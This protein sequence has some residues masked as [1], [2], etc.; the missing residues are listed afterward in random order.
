MKRI[1]SLLLVALLAMTITCSAFTFKGK[2]VDRSIVLA[3]DFLFY[4]NFYASFLSTGHT[5]SVDNAEEISKLSDSTLCKWIFN[6][7]E[8]MTLNLNSD[9]DKVMSVHCTLSNGSRSTYY[10][11]DFLILLME[12]LLA[13][14]LEYDSVSD[15]FTKVGKAQTLK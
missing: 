11:D 8:I 9:G 15:L 6:G 7:C 3:E 5:L 14:G 13:C 10:T 2:T 1:I 12:A 4:F